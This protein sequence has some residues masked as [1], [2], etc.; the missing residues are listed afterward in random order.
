MKERE[1]E[2]K[3]REKK[4][5][6]AQH[7]VCMTHFYIRNAKN[8]NNESKTLSNSFSTILAPLAI[9]SKNHYG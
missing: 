3:A 6:C 5:L 4:L 1:R 9:N 2:I 8:S 7:T